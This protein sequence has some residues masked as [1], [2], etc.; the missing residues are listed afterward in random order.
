MSGRRRT[1]DHYSKRAKKENYPARSV[2]KLQEIDRRVN[3]LK[4]GYKVLDLG[5]APGSWTLYASDR[6][7]PNGKVLAVDRAELTIAIPDNVISIE[8]DALACEPTELLSHIDAPGFDA[9]ISDMAPRTSGHRFVDQSRSFELFDRA[10]EIAVGALRPGGK[11]VGK[12]FQGEDFETA[13]D[14]VRSLFVKA[15]IIKPAG[16]RAESYEIYLVGLERK[17]KTK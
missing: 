2:Y 17:G 14:K 12:I 16:V 4:R 11:F 9:V 8:G 5:A 7:G 1:R 3:L 10:L 6:V 15:R 13:R